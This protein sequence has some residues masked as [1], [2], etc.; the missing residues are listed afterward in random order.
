MNVVSCKLLKFKEDPEE[1]LK[2]ELNKI[3]PKDIK[4]FKLIEMSNK[5]NAKNANNHREYHYILPTFAL[6]PRLLENKIEYKD[7]NDYICDYNYKISPEF[8]DKV[9][10]FS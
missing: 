4:I 7:E 5:F 10:I 6:Q 3:L 9:M 8:H 1:E 2:V